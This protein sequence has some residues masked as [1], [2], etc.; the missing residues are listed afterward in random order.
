MADFR[1]T[2]AS[3]LVSILAWA[4]AEKEPVEVLGRGTKRGL[5]RP[6]EA[7]HRLDLSQ[8]SGIRLYE[9]A[10]LVLTVGAA[11]PL[12]EIEAVL[13]DA[14]QMLAFEP[15]DWGELLGGEAGGQ[16]LGGI[17]SCNFGG[18]RRLKMGAARDHLLGF[19]GVNGRGEAF[20]AGGRVVKNVTGYDLCKL[21][22]GS[23]GTLAALAEVTVKVLPRPEEEATLLILGLNDQAAIAAMTEALNS[24]H[25][26][27]A[28]A[29]L[30]A[31]CGGLV[32]GVAG[33]VTA[34]RIEGPKPSVVARLGV[35]RELLGT[36][37]EIADL[38]RGQ[39][40]QDIGDAKPF[41]GLPDHVVWRVS[42]APS[43]GAALAG[44][45]G[46]RLDIRHFYDWGGGL[47]WLAVAG[48]E[49]GG[50]GAIRE[51]IKAG[52]GHATLIR[53]PEDFRREVP[54]FEPLA[55]GLAALTARVKAGFDPQGILN[56]GRL[57]RDM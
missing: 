47:L 33:S 10:E 26:I 53:G 3:D 16:S 14:D 50:A 48:A 41:A 46:R 9:P 31:A 15:P 20:K 37:G 27:S 35:L 32:P 54:V 13:R 49:D 34:L 5:G 11:T 23:Y 19:S 8:L 52:G 55:P 51:A 22:C 4:A 12:A 45:L 24:P 42:V 44:D 28:A 2:D 21:L 57:Y 6:V 18:P 38:P 25:E 1:P 36:H 39:L 17:L 30:P 29:H 40:W 56:P 7:A 43:T